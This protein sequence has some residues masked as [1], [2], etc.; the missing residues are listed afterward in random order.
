VLVVGRCIGQLWRWG[1]SGL[2]SVYSTS[3]SMVVVSVMDS[4]AWTA[5]LALGGSGL[6]SPVE[7]ESG[8]F[9]AC[10]RRRGRRCLSLRRKR[11]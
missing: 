11:L 1:V 3:A 8:L 5:L 9:G 2:S 7:G 10:R 6:T 4:L